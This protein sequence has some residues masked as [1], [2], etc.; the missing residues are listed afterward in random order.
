MRRPNRVVIDPP[1][2]PEHATRR[3]ERAFDRIDRRIGRLLV[4][5]AKRKT[6][7][8]MRRRR[9]RAGGRARRDDRRSILS[10]TRRH[11]WPERREG[12]MSA[13][14]W[15]ILLLLTAALTYAST[16]VTNHA[17]AEDS[18]HYAAVAA[19][20]DFRSELLVHGDHLLYAPLAHLAVR[21]TRALGL[22]ATAEVPL[23]IASVMLAVLALALFSRVVA[24]LDVATPIRAGL[25]LAVIFSYA[26]WRYATE[27]DVYM[28]PFLALMVVWHEVAATLGRPDRPAAGLRL[29]G[30]CAFGI[31]SH[32]QQVLTLLAAVGALG[33]D[34][35]VPK[36]LRLRRIAVTVAVAGAW[37]AG[38]YLAAA[39]F[40]FRGDGVEPLDWIR[41]PGGSGSWG[42]LSPATLLRAPVGL[43]RTLIGGHFFLAIPGLSDLI[44]ARFSETVL[45]EERFLARAFS[46]FGAMA[47][48]AS[49]GIAA[50]GAALAIHRS[51]RSRSAH[52]PTPAFVNRFILPSVVLYAFFAAWWDPDNVEFWMPV[53]PGLA[54]LSGGFLGHAKPDRPALAL[55]GVAIAGL[56]AVNLFGSILPQCDPRYDYWRRVNRPIAEHARAGD[57]VVSGSGWVSQGYVELYTGAR[58]FST[59]R[60]DSLLAG[61]FFRCVQANAGGRVFVSSSV[62]DPPAA[63]LAWRKLDPAPARALFARL[64]PRLRLLDSDEQALYE[65]LPAP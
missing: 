4:S 19:R 47:L 31:L 24:R 3:V 36:A 30:A 60:D 34:R 40:W 14:G 45:D 18:L 59:L 58:V 15:T 5:S 25:V 35:R 37:T 12:D 61:D 8:V 21:L 44:G 46:P 22:H 63:L 48:L 51:T 38:V 7:A 53:V 43:V 33:L 16:L 64:E 52:A 20:G 13:R 41:G 55:G 27:S 6:R 56:A 11:T 62:V 39:G 65:W 50:L 32:Q 1:A 23:Q 29:G 17:G 26:I 2:S 42:H 49:T 57:I 10:G 54:A 28:L 9:N